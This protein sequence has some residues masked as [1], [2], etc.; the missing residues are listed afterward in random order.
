MYDVCVIGAGA[1]GVIAGIAAA[2]RGKKVLILDKN[3]KICRKIY[4]TGNGKCNMTNENFSI[5]ANYNSE[6]VDYPLFLDHIL[7]KGHLQF[8]CLMYYLHLLHKC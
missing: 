3:K 5:A 2:K 6:S 4:S 7:L 8:S 1:S